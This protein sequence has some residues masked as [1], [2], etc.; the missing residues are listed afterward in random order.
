MFFDFLRRMVNALRNWCVDGSD[1]I[2]PRAPHFT[3][4]SF[5]TSNGFKLKGT[6]IMTNVEIT[7]TQGFSFEVGGAVDALGNPAKL[8]GGIFISVEPAD[9][10]AVI[11]FDPSETGKGG[12]VTATG[13]PGVAQLRIAA[14][15]DLTDG[16]QELTETIQVNVVA[17]KAVGFAVQIGQVFEIAQ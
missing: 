12:K 6:L 7:V 8:D 3:L 1:E 4:T 11:R 16:I 13:K 15:A 14:D 5:E 17:G 10:D 9:G 2:P